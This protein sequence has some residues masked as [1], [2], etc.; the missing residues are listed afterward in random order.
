MKGSALVVGSIF[1]SVLATWTVVAQTESHP[2][3]LHDASKQ[4][5]NYS[6]HILPL[7]NNNTGDVFMAYIAYV[8]ATNSR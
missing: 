8:P 5:S 2:A 4:G 7:P 3:G 1:L 6:V